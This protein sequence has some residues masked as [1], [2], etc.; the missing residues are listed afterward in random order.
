[1]DRE[2]KDKNR[3]RSLEKGLEILLLLSRHEA[4]L[5]LEDISQE[6]GFS[7][8][9]C[10]RLLQT[11]RRN[12]F[13]KQSSE[14]KR[15]QLGPRNIAIGTA[16][17]DRQSVR[18]IAVP[19]MRRIRTQTGETVNLTILDGIEIV[20]VERI[21]GKFIVNSNLYVG[22]RLPVHCSSMGKA[23]LAHLPEHKL[24]AIVEKLDFQQYT[25]KTLVSR[26]QLYKELE[27]IQAEGTSINNEE[28]EKG[29]FAIAGPIR[30]YSGEA[31][32]AL[33]VSFPLARHRIQDALTDFVPVIKQVCMEISGL[34]GFKAT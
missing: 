27:K 31:I 23:I 18:A 32:A 8:P 21:E 4:E 10:Y 26:E 17:M 20:F 1:M 5:S 30:D 22:S 25:Q 7:K 33:N 6:A 16:A 19:Y 13:V 9:T 29:L 2:S 3:I 34:M 14:T 15:Y 11:M 28:L 24:A 12:N